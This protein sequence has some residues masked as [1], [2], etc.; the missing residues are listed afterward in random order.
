MKSCR[1]LSHCYFYLMLSHLA[2]WTPARLQILTEFQ[3][4]GLHL[5][6]DGLEGI[7]VPLLAL[8]SFVECALLLADLEQKRDIT[9]R[10]LA[11]YLPD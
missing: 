11:P 5:R 1:K 9:K 8:Q 7:L 6:G 10:S 3:L 4:D 2:L